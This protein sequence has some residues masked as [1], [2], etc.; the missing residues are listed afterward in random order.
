MNRLRKI[1]EILVAYGQRGLAS[2]VAMLSLQ[3]KSSAASSERTAGK[4][5][6]NKTKAEAVISREVDRPFLDR[7]LEMFRH[8]TDGDTTISNLRVPKDWPLGGV[9]SFTRDAD[10]RPVTMGLD[11]KTSKW[12]A[13]AVPS[14]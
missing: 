9:I 14:K 12:F 4:D 6:L 5:V 8:V 3:L 1:A 11:K 7:A 10:G 2:E 13:R